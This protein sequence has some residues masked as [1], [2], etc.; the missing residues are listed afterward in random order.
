MTAQTAEGK[1]GWRSR[2]RPEETLEGANE[3]FIKR[4]GQAWEAKRD[5]FLRSHYEDRI[6]RTLVAWIMIEERKGA[7]YWSVFSQSDSLEL[8]PGG[9]ARVVGR[10]DLVLSVRNHQVVYECKRLNILNGNGSVRANVGEYINEGLNRFTVDKKYSI[11]SGVCGMIGYVMDGDV[12]TAHRALRSR[13]DRV[14]RPEH[15]I[16]PDCPVPGAGNYRLRTVHPA[17]DKASFVVHH[18]LFPVAAA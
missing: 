3:L 18:L 7:G 1:A 4:L 11:T 8:E 2:L 13:L 6:S 14:C 9:E 12:E 16:D 10:C 15:V 17:T 5:V